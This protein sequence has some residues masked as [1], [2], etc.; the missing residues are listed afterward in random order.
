MEKDKKL[1]LVVDDEP[2]VRIFISTVLE[3]HGYRTMLAEDGVDALAKLRQE[4]PDLISLD[5]TMPE[6]S[7]VRFYRELKSDEQLK[8]IPIIM[9]T[10][11]SG[12]FQH[13]ISTRQ[14]VPPPEGY[15]AKPIDENEILALVGRL[16]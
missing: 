16:I 5:V 3:D 13:F 15:L 10:G 11:M 12:E 6:K 7:G 8:G 9:V 4:R 1:V 14:Q 2:D